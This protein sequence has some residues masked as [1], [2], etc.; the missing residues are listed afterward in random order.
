MKRGRKSKSDQHK[1][2]MARILDVKQPWPWPKITPLEIK[3]EFETGKPLPFLTEQYI[4]KLY[5]Y[6]IRK[7]NEWAKARRVG[8]QAPEAQPP[9]EL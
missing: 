2:N 4:I 1:L 5:N 6:G 8:G 9:G 7:W 3:Y